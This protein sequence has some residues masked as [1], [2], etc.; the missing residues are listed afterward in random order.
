MIKAGTEE[1]IFYCLTGL[2]GPETQTV[3]KLADVGRLEVCVCVCVRALVH[4]K[5]PGRQGQ[6]A[7]IHLPRGGS[8]HRG[9]REA[10]Q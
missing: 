10:E 4:A 8:I 7:L 6:T 3:I 9:E 1:T 5:C 2:E